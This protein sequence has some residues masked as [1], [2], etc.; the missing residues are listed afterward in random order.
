MLI[1]RDI[2]ENKLHEKFWKVAVDTKF[3]QKM[4]DYAKNEFNMSEEVFSDFVADRKALQEAT[5]YMLFVMLKSYEYVKETKTSAISVYFSQKEIDTY[6]FSKFDN[7]DFEF[8]I[9]FEMLQINDDQWI[10]KIDVNTLDKLR[11]HQ[12]INYNPD[13]Q[14]TM[15]KVIRKGNV[16]YKITVN[17][18]A[19]AEIADSFEEGTY[20]SDE[21]TLNIRPD[22][23]KADFYYDFKKRMLI[24]N[25]ITAFD[26]NDGYHRYLGMFREKMVHPE[27]NYTMELR[28]TNFDVD[29]SQRFIYQKDQ[30]TKMA[31]VDSRSYNVYDPAN[32]VIKKINE[33]ASCNI[34][35]FIGRNEAK[36]D[37]GTL[38]KIVHLLYFKNVLKSD[39]R[40]MIIEVTKE[41]IEDFNMLTEQNIEFLEKTYS[42]YELLCIMSAFHYF[43]GKDNKEDIGD[44]VKYLIDATQGNSVKL[45]N[46]SGITRKKMEQLEE[47]IERRNKT[48][49]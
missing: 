3:Q 4:F 36:I 16:N 11:K 2:L 19:V 13:T 47:I 35:G 41:L 45:N 1:N 49:V 31:K 25:N 5:E 8:P 34:R 32:I 38:S 26:I 28:I 22:D 42:T 40:K 37:F 23:E 33:S 44:T 12:L 18:K 24:I 20:I 9:V 6:S 43:K 46:R 30:K 14:R 48:Y 27:F 10:G 21:L 29:K 17:K 39:E 15:Q 7:A